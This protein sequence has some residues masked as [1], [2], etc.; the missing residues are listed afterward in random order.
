MLNFF[1][2]LLQTSIV[3]SFTVSSLNLQSVF[4][5]SP[6]YV[7]GIST[8][9]AGCLV[10]S[11]VFQIIMTFVFVFVFVTFKYAFTCFAYDFFSF[12]WNFSWFK[13]FHFFSPFSHIFSMSSGTSGSLNLIDPEIVDTPNASPILKYSCRLIGIRT[14]SS[15]LFLERDR[16]YRHS[17]E[18]LSAVHWQLVDTFSSPYRQPQIWHKP[19]DL[20]LK[21]QSYG[22]PSLTHSSQFRV[23]CIPTANLYRTVQYLWSSRFRHP[24]HFSLFP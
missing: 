24:W 10:I 17:F 1:L 13:N 4:K 23:S 12:I 3:G 22:F 19:L 15:I 16:I 6:P 11:T 2:H 21:Y 5:H 7:Y 18:P 9:R 8:S 14:A 20:R